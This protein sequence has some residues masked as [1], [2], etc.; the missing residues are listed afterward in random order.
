VNPASAA[1]QGY[2][3]F[4][5]AHGREAL[6]WLAGLCV[7]AALACLA[8]ALALRL[9]T[10]V[11]LAGGLAIGVAAVV[12]ALKRKRQPKDFYRTYLGSPAW[13]A[14]AAAARKRA[15]YRC[16]RCHKA[17]PLDV[18]HLTYQ[19]LGHERPEQLLAVCHA[20][21]WAL[22]GKV[23]RIPRKKYTPTKRARV[24]KD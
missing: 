8:G 12:R 14:R 17:G 21:H 1:V 11:L 23:A 5:V 6:P 3:G 13:K 24:G 7:V 19:D 9:A 22:H 4:W 18:H 16:S 10:R 15:G 20:C 2:V